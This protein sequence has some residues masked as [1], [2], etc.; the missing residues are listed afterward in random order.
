[1]RAV[2]VALLVAVAGSCIATDDHRLDIS[3]DARA[4]AAQISSVTLRTALQGRFLGAQDGG[5]GAVVATATTAAAWETFS[6][7]DADGGAL[8]SGDTVYLRTGGGQFVR[9]EGGGGAG[10]DATSTAARAWETFRIVRSSGAGVIRSGDVVGLQA[11]RGAWVSAEQ[12]GGGAVLTYGAALGPWEQL[13]ISLGAAV[14][15]ATRIA[16]V[17]LRTASRGRYVGAQ[18]GGGAAVIATATTP[19]AWETFSILD[20]NGGA[21]ESGDVVHV[22]AGNGQYLQA[23]GGGGGAL[24][25]GGTAQLDWESFRVVST[26]GGAIAT[27]D[28]VGLQ[29]FTGAWVSAEGGGGAGVLAYG[30]S[31]G[32]WERFVI[33]LGATRWVTG[34]EA[35]G[36]RLVWSD[37]FDG[38]ALDESKWSYEVQGPGWVNHELQ[39]YTYRRRENA[40]VEGGHL[41]LE[42]RR[43]FVGGEYSSARLK[44]AGH[45]SWTYGR[46][47]ARIHV[48]AG[49]GTWPAF[50]MM[51]DDQSRGWPGCGEIDIMEHVGHD[52]N[53]V[54]GTT[55]S[56]A[57][58][59]RSPRQRT[60]STRVAGA[61]SGFHVYALEWWPDRIEVSVDGV[62]Y[63]TSPNDNTGDDAWPFHKNFHVILNLAVGGDWGG[64]RGVDPNI[65]PRQMRVDYVRVYQR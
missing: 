21:L 37:E 20:G 47:E 24:G 43:D 48:P 34:P 60:A 51:P 61:T 63:F 3:S 56:N 36:W 30:T 5:G 22:L 9:A 19:A 46:V 29:A 17:T 33:G 8:E 16:G 15:A 49:W 4:L 10:L 18:N 58:N 7:I 27:G 39:A 62:R 55:H 28:A 25:A 50:W 57:Y 41:V 42:A 1:M 40:R 12:G 26:A 53:V 32:D 65:W 44:T 6:L 45:A 38:G 11:A 2:P 31:L 64:A 52:E 13:V 54:H 23:A 14:P 35:A 59:W